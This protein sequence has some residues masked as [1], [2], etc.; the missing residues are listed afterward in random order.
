VGGD[1]CPPG[2]P[3]PLKGHQGGQVQPRVQKKTVADKT[4]IPR[5]VQAHTAVCTGS[6][7]YEWQDTPDGKQPY[8]FTRREAAIT[9]QGCG[10]NARKQ[11]GE[12]S[13]HVR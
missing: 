1:L 10:I 6:G 9:L 12:R 8:Y 13:S 3:K 4:H 7:Y 5:R 2:W 11:Q